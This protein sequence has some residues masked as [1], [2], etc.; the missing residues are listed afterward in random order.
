[1][2]ILLS[3]QFIGCPHQ[4]EGDCNSKDFNGLLANLLISY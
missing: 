1:L 2:H 4:K 3:N